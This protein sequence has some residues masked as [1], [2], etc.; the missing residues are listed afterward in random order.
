MNPNYYLPSSIVDNTTKRLSPVKGCDKDSAV[1]QVSDA[2]HI[3]HR[4]ETHFIYREDLKNE[5]WTH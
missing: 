3:L 1:F 5:W 2:D 4:E